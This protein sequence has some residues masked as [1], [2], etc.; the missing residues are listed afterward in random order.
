MKLK[1]P[2]KNWIRRTLKKSPAV[3]RFI[4]RLNAALN[5]D[6]DLPEL[7][8]YFNM[9]FTTEEKPLFTQKAMYKG[10]SVDYLN[11][12]LLSKEERAC[13]LKRHFYNNCHYYLDL[14]NPKT[15]N[16]KLQWLKLNYS[17]LSMSRCVDKCEFKRYIAEQLGEGYTVPMYGEWT[18][19]NQIDFE[20]LPK[21]FV[22]KSNVQSDGRHIIVV[23][24]KSKLDLD[25]LK[26]IMSSWLL[27][28][29]TLCASYCSAYKPVQPKILAEEFIEGF[30]NS[31]TDYKFMCFNGEA[32]MLFVVADRAE[33]MCVN[34][35]DLD[36]NLL[37]FTRKYPN[38]SYPLKKPK[39]F[40]TML[41]IANKLAKPFP[42]VRV[43]F[44]ESKD[45]QNVY[46]GELTFYPGGG[47]E[48]FEPMEWDYKLGDM[49][50]LPDANI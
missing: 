11:S 36:W 23:K 39:N 14:D 19:E 42:F 24:D 47:Y 46:V 27:P 28:R 35:Y 31:L 32:K 50:T 40:D 10:Y 6:S 21:Q 3:C 30:D 7:N 5:N 49:L 18:N 8:S 20:Q 4:S 15:F 26:T 33:N 13:E 45:E 16:Q 2:L 22:L 41:K 48:T 17:T 9:Q 1:Q 25:K 44:Y 34:F 12:K 38:T 29:N 37:P 43:D